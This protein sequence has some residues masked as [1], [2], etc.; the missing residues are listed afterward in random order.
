M[1]KDI[2][3]LIKK[4][5]QV[6]YDSIVCPPKEEIWNRIISSLRK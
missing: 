4:A 1:E 5:L 6:R 2:D 3:S